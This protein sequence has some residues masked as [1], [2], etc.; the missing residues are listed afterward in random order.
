M[1]NQLLEKMATTAL[2][3]YGVQKQTFQ[4]LSELGELVAVLA[5]LRQGTRHDVLADDVR[6]EIADV[7][8]VLYQLRETFGS[9]EVDAMIEHKLE[10]LQ[11]RIVHWRQQLNL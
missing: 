9:D 5:R 10:R 11:Q 6:E 4:A 7:F 8:I 2:Y 3:T 1:N